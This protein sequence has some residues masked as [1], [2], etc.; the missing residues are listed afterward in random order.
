MGKAREVAEE[1]KSV[2]LEKN[3]L[4]DVILP[5]LVFL[6]LDALAGFNAALW[7]TLITAAGFTFYRVA[8]KQSPVYSLVGLGLAAFATFSAFLAGKP[9]VAFLPGILTNGLTVAAALI[10]NLVGRPLVAFTSHLARGWELR[11]YWHPR[12][13]PAYS[14]VTWAWAV[15][16]AI[17]LALQL[18]AFDVPGSAN[19]LVWIN[20]LLGYPALIILL[21][22]SYLYGLWRLRRL[23]GPSLEEFMTGAPPPWR[24]Q[25]RGF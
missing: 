2:V 23:Q 12:V 6:A 21:V 14:E 9:Q 10:S 22:A 18:A 16:F 3:N 20:L 25:V 5:S 15:F 7:G 4:V 1:L 17:K 19:N 24:G 11:W 13:R 8:K